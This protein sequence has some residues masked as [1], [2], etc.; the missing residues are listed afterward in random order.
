VH[1]Y[2]DPGEITI[3]EPEHDMEKVIDKFLDILENTDPERFVT[4]CG[5]Y[6]L[7]Y[8]PRIITI[9]LR[10]NS[11]NIKNR[12]N[13]TFRS[14]WLED[15]NDLQRIRL[16]TVFYEAQRQERERTSEKET[17]LCVATLNKIKEI[18]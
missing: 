4:K 17:E 12:V 9:E 15:L 14:V 1:P 10:P 2:R 6:E 3:R 8:P 18:K 13:N 16:N 7:N 11:I 5:Y